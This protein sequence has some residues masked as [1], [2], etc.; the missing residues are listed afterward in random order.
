VKQMA[1]ILRIA[2]A[3][4]RSHTQQVTQTTIHLEDGHLHLE[5]VANGDP[6]VDLWA[7]RSRTELFCRVFEMEVHVSLDR[8]RHSQ[9]SASNP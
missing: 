6:E 7:A 5:I 2:G 3:L 4:D 8:E 9:V 1:A